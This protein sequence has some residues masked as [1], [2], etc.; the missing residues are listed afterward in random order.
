MM[1]R[2]IKEYASYKLKDINSN[3]LMQKKFKDEKIAEINKIV[4]YKK[5]GIVS[6]DEAMNLISKV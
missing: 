1:K 6:I 2:F 3:E 5:R 4:M